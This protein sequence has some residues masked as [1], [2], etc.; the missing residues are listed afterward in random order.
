MEKI[1]A[2]N[3]A[4][5]AQLRAEFFAKVSRDAKELGIDMR[6]GNI[7]FDAGSFRCQVEAKVANP[8]PLV[9]AVTNERANLELQMLGVEKK[10]GDTFIHLGKQYEI[11]D[12]NTRRSKYPV[13]A[14]ETRS[15][16]SFKFP[17]VAVR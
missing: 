11:T 17:A 9:A 4:N 7:R 10:V 12:V 2:F 15:G 13:S 3:K 14:V 1:T 5:L 16:K 6:F 8:N